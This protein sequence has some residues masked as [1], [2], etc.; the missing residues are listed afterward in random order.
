MITP[1]TTIPFT[2]KTSPT[3]SPTIASRPGAFTTIADYIKEN[4]ITETPVK[5]M[6]PGTPI[7]DLPIP[8]GWGDA[9]SR[10]PDY[11]FG[12]IVGTD[13]TMA[14]DPPSIVALMSKLTGDVDPAKILEYAPGD[15]REDHD[16]A[17]KVS[18]PVVYTSRQAMLRDNVPA[19]LVCAHASRDR[20][21]LMRSI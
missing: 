2:P 20:A 13:P 3:S 1:T 6:D 11:A 17:M 15:R 7:L 21:S 10:T 16:H 14:A 12:A 5:R 9:G 4:G 19:V 18:Y 8:A